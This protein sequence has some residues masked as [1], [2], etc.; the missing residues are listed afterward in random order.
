MSKSTTEKYRGL[1][2]ADGELTLMKSR[3]FCKSKDFNLSL[4]GD[5]PEQAIVNFWVAR[6][7]R[8]EN[9]KWQET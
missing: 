6:G 1:L 4:S 7:M 8:I 5:T 2:P 9:K 3:W